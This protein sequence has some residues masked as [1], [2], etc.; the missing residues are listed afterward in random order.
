MGFFQNIFGSTIKRFTISIVIR[1]Q[2]IQRWNLSKRI[3]KS[4]FV[5]WN[6]VQITGPCFHKRKQTGTVKS[7]TRSQQSI[8]MLAVSNYK[9]EGL[10]PSVPSGISEVDHFYIIILN[11][12]DQVIFCQLFCRLI[13]VLNKR[14]WVH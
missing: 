13:Q 12:P 3:Y 11:I 9:I 2:N 14:I 4:C 10:Q 8:K 1:T 5:S 7:L 6:N